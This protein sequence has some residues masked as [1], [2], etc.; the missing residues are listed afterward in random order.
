MLSGCD[1]QLHH[2]PD[3]DHGNECP[4]KGEASVK[5]PDYYVIASFELHSVYAPDDGR[6]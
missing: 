5:Y 2:M 1:N 4:H 6:R 3:D